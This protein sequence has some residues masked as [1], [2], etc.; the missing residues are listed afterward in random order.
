M[1]LF[2][3]TSGFSYP[4]WKGSFY[5]AELPEKQMLRYYAE[6]FATV[7]I[8]NTFHRMPKAAQLE[9][10]AAQV[11]PGFR[12][13][14]KAPQRITHWQRLRDTDEAVSY[15]LGVAGVL[16]E[17]LGPVL[18]QLPPDF[19]KDIALL[20]GFL[21]SLPL[22]HYRIAFEFRHRSWFDEEVY[23]LLRRSGVALCHADGQNDFEVPLEPT[24]DWGYLRLRRP[25]YPGA[26]LEEWA[27]RL[28]GLSWRQAF[29]FFKHEDE[30]RGPRLARQLLELG[31]DRQ[32]GRIAA[33]SEVV[34][35]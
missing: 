24:A 10:W 21:L 6:Q 14:L 4:Q 22:K 15:F 13:A 7:E 3:G 9:S 34:S 1:E 17:H 33:G 8:N 18:F 31:G 16:R 32:G 35:A 25:E 28:R 23:A 2:V 11:P 12:F 26:R 30:A 20:R 19:P 27:A 5:P 29:V